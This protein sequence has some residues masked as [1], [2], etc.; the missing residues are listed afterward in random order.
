MGVVDLRSVRGVWVFVLSV[1]RHLA[2][3]RAVS[4][5]GELR[6]LF[7]YEPL[8]LLRD[9]KLHLDI[10]FSVRHTP[11]P[12]CIRVWDYPKGLP[13]QA[14]PARVQAIL[15]FRARDLKI[16]KIASGYSLAVLAD[17]FVPRIFP[18][19]HTTIRTG[20][21][22]QLAEKLLQKLNPFKEKIQIIHFLLLHPAPFYAI[23]MVRTP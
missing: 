4:P 14:K 8:F 21:F 9:I 16:Q 12:F 11:P 23:L 22:G 20:R 10:P 17:Y 5:G 15:N 3:I 1:Y 2:Q 6:H 7:I 19:A 13:Q 18:S